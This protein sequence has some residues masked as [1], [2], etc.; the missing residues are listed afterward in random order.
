MAIVL[1]SAWDTNSDGDISLTELNAQD[2]IIVPGTTIYTE[3]TDRLNLNKQNLVV[4]ANE[5]LSVNGIVNSFNDNP[6]F[7]GNQFNTATL[8]NNGRITARAGS[9]IMLQAARPTATLNG[10]IQSGSGASRDVTIDAISGTIPESGVMIV[11]ATG[12]SLTYS[13]FTTTSP[14]N[15]TLTLDAVSSTAIG[16]GQVVEFETAVNRFRSGSLD[17]SGATVTMTDG[18][19]N[20]T[21]PAATR[22][23]DFRT[24][25]PG[26]RDTLGV[27]MDLTNTRIIGPS[28]DGSVWFMHGRSG[29][30]DGTRGGTFNNTI[31]RNNVTIQWTPTAD[32]VNVTTPETGRVADTGTTGIRLGTTGAFRLITTS[33]RPTDHA[34]WTAFIDGVIRWQTVS[35]TTNYTRFE[36]NPLHFATN[37]VDVLIIGAGGAAQF[38]NLPTGGGIGLAGRGDRAQNATAHRIRRMFAWKPTFRDIATLGNPIPTSITDVKLDFNLVGTNQN[39]GEALFIA[40]DPNRGVATDQSIRSAGTATTLNVSGSRDYW[41]SRGVSN[42]QNRR[43]PTETG[44]AQFRIVSISGADDNVVL[45]GVFLN[46]ATTTDFASGDDLFFTRKTAGLSALRN[47][48]DT[49][50]EFVHVD[51]NGYW[52]QTHVQTGGAA[53]SENIGVSGIQP[54]SLTGT[55]VPRDITTERNVNAWS[56]HYN[57]PYTIQTRHHRQSDTGVFSEEQLEDRVR[58]SFVAATD[59]PTTIDALDGSGAT[60]NTFENIYKRIRA[61]WYEE[62]IRESISN[63]IPGETYNIFDTTTLGVLGINKNVDFVNSAS[64]LSLSTGATGI[65]SIPA[66]TASQISSANSPFTTMNVLGNGSLA[67]NGNNVGAGTFNS[68]TIAVTGG[69]Y[70]GINFNARRTTTGNSI[71][72]GTAA[73]TINNSTLTSGSNIRMLRGWGNNVSL[74]T[75]TSGTLDVNN[76]NTGDN[77]TI[78]AD[79]INNW[80]VTTTHGTGLTINGATTINLNRVSASQADTLASDIFGSDAID[81]TGNITLTANNPITIQTN[82]ARFRAGNNV[83]LAAIPVPPVGLTIRPD[84]APEDGFM[85]VRVVDRITNVVKLNTTVAITQGR[86]TSTVTLANNSYD[87]DDDVHVWYKPNNNVTNNVIYRTTYVSF[88]FEP[89][90]TNSE[91]RIQV[92]TYVDT[93]TANPTGVTTGN[94]ADDRFT[95]TVDGAINNSTTL[96]VDGVTLTGAPILPNRGVL[97]ING[98]SHVYT[99]YTIAANGEYTFTLREAATIADGLAVMS[100]VLTLPIS[101]AEGRQLQTG[102]ATQSVYL[103][104]ANN[105]TYIN[106]LRDHTLTGDIIVPDGR[107]ALSINFDFITLTSGNGNQQNVTAISDR[108]SGSSP[109]TTSLPLS[110]ATDIGYD[111]TARS[112]TALPNRIVYTVNDAAANIQSGQLLS[113]LASGPF[114]SVRRESATTFSIPTPGTDPWFDFIPGNP[115]NIFRQGTINSVNIGVNPEGATIQDIILGFNSSEPGSEIIEINNKV[116]YQLGDGTRTGKFKPNA[117]DY[118]PDTNYRDINE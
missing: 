76:A 9:T 118:D 10:A 67:F 99:S 78:D 88:P 75:G 53:G 87:M 7:N 80:S 115:Q 64:S 101:G 33:G 106:F 107:N 95:A 6:N 71:D 109:E 66:T 21:F 105:S 42:I 85:A 37:S 15:G 13:G 38:P 3:A 54:M 110:M 113:D 4:E 45:T 23:D 28:A 82:N 61:Y 83:M 5:V 49:D 44:F 79:T 77:T 19:G 63:D 62:G 92:N 116:S 12:F 2:N 31:F 100:S 68:N 18:A 98:N 65:V 86:T 103:R 51:G 89:L 58:N 17:F 56:Y 26:L 69:T 16:D 52:I 48:S 41:N 32:W 36:M 27:S 70:N 94:I 96:V 47:G 108:G 111:I 114:V 43:T 20:F 8:D 30:D 1:Q 93:S 57:V 84:T 14:G 91:R 72:F 34:R 81:G 55:R 46:G 24:V 59:N 117:G 29:S 73:Y 74:T 39:N 25:A 35:E 97:L 50:N 11:A 104:F 90:L 112:T 60:D 40:Q 102:G 22:I